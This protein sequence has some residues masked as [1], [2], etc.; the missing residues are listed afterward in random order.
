LIRRVIE[1]MKEVGVDVSEDRPKE[2]TDGSIDG[3][4]MIALTDA[5]LRTAILSNLRRRM[6]KKVKVERYIFSGKTD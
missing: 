3:A 2:L 5:S 6:R 4:N 1:T